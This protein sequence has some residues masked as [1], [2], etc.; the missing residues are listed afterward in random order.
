MVNNC[1]NYV[2]NRHNLLVRC[3]L[4]RVYAHR[5][6]AVEG[7]RRLKHWQNELNNLRRRYYDDPRTI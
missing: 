7:S 1:E 5:I 3:T 6:N 2:H 4:C